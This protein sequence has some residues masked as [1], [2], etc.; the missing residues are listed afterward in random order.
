MDD[1][2]CAGR[3]VMAALDGRDAPEGLSDTTIA[4]VQLARRFGMG[5]HVPLRVSAAGLQL[6]RLGLGA[7]I[8]DAAKQD[9]FPAH[10]RFQDGRVTLAPESP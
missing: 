4:A 9:G 10:V 5:W 8:D 2:Y 6:E 3:L 1:V 7:D